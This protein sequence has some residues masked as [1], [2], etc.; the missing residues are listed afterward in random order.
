[1][2]M[3]IILIAGGALAV[4]ILVI[5]LGVSLTSDR[6]MVE[7]RLGRYVEQDVPSEAEHQKSKAPVTEWLNTRVTGSSFGD[8]LSRDLARADLKLKPGEFIAITIILAF[9]L[10]FWASSSP[11]G[12]SVRWD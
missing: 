2:D 11:V 9:G 3:T 10:G 6:S 4:I 5:G 12:L 1:M 8:S 7:E